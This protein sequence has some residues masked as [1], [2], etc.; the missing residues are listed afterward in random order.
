MHFYA[1]IAGTG[2]SGGGVLTRKITPN[3]L[4]SGFC[5]INKCCDGW[6]YSNSKAVCT[7]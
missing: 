1:F 4:L 7:L 2:S 6:C 3:H 5:F